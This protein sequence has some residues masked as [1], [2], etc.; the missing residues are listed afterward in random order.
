MV[1]EGRPFRGV[2]YAGLMLTP[3]GPKLLEYNVRFGDPECQVLMMR[4]TSD[5]LPALI[6]AA[7]GALD[8]ISLRWRDDAAVVVVMVAEGYPGPY[9][10][11]TAIRGLGEAEGEDVTRSEEHTS[12]LQSLM[13]ISY[14]VF[15]LKKKK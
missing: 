6:A 10:K 14:A 4:L 8:T 3:E 1:A 7:D 9:R 5:V 13:R 11:G 2:L 12:E 15:C